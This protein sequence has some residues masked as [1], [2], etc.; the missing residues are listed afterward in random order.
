MSVST[1]SHINLCLDFKTCAPS[2]GKLQRRHGTVTVYDFD[3]EVFKLLT[4]SRTG[5]KSPPPGFNIQT[6]IF[7]DQLQ[8][9]PS[10]DRLTWCIAQYP[11]VF[12]RIRCVTRSVAHSQETNWQVGISLSGG[13]SKRLVHRYTNQSTDRSVTVEMLKSGWELSEAKKRHEPATGEGFRRTTHRV[14][15]CEEVWKEVN[16]KGDSCI[17]P[18]GMGAHLKWKM[19][20]KYVELTFFPSLN[21]TCPSATTV[22]VIFCH[23]FEQLRVRVCVRAY[24]GSLFKI[25][26]GVRAPAGRLHPASCAIRPPRQWETRPPPSS[27]SAKLVQLF[28]WI[29]YCL[30]WS[31][32]D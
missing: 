20:R 6:Q 2:H 27:P 19:R 24:R 25:A 23:G 3:W 7:S 29:K 11:H 5:T 8:K 9:I 1:A 28:L 4:L 18:R 31:S 12:T 26:F 32:F 22:S 17:W 13:K 15:H 21:L 10:L 14:F 30:Q 16:R